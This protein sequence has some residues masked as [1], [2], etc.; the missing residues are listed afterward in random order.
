MCLVLG[1]LALVRERINFSC[2][3]TVCQELRY[4]VSIHDF[5]PSSQQTRE[6]DTVITV[7]F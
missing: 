1:F 6:G 5:I 3:P 4:K 2:V 7:M